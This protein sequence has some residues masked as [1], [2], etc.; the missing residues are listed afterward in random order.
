MWSLPRPGKEIYCTDPS[1]KEEGHTKLSE[2][3]L[4]K[5]SSMI[6]MCDDYLSDSKYFLEKG[7]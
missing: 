1:S 2:E 4:E 5:L 6:R 7:I 3:D